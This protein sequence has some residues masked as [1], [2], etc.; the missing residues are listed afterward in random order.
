V[1]G[2]GGRDGL[3]IEGC[4]IL[5]RQFRQ[6]IEAR[7][8]KS[9]GADRAKAAPA[10]ST[11][12]CSCR[13]RLRSFSVDRRTRRSLDWLARQLGDARRAAQDRRAS[14][15]VRRSAVTLRPCCH[16][17][18][19]LHVRGNAARGGGPHL[20]I[21]WPTL[22]F[23]L[24]PLSGPTDRAG[25]GSRRHDSDEGRSGREGSDPA[26]RH[27]WL[28]WFARGVAD[29]WA[30]SRRIDMAKIP[31]LDLVDQLV[32]AVRDASPA[33]PHGPEGRLDGPWRPWL[34]QLP[35]RSLFASS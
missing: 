26:S 8:E 13:S 18:W 33:T 31:L 35:P 24:T 1:A 4:H 34:V 14:E 15:P 25:H 20:V 30:R 7:D 21:R 12:T 10:P 17:V 27:R 23:V 3:S 6:R 29:P 28:Q 32:A 22:R 9:R 11:S 5:A 16:L 19:V 2:R